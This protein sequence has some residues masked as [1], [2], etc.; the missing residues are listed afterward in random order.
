[1]AD[2]AERLGLRHVVVTSVTRDDLADGGA[3]V[4]AAT[5][6]A[7]RERS[8][9]VVIEVLIPDFQGSTDALDSVIE[10]RPDVIGHNLETV[11]RLYPGVRCGASYERSVELLRRVAEAGQRILTKSGIM[12]GL[13]ETR[14]ELVE[15]FHDLVSA[16]CRVLTI[17]QYLRPTR[18]HH[19]VER[20]VPPDEFDELKDMA[21]KAGMRNVAAGPL[22]RSSYR[23]GEIFRLA[24]SSASPLPA[25]EHRNDSV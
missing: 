15:L 17:G 20:Y 13:G 14:A 23:A 8:P 2:A 1:V 12:V 22:V 5:I 24:G 6:R 19:P 16:K 25:D 7:L 4:F 9:G 18:S 3:R 11:A 21:L 10:A